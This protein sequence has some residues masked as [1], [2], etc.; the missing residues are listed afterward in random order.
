MELGLDCVELRLKEAL[1]ETRAQ[2]EDLQR[3]AFAQA[4]QQ[5]A[6]VPVGGSSASTSGF[7]EKAVRLVSI[8][9]ANLVSKV[10]IFS[11][12]DED[13]KTWRFVFESTTGLIFGRR[14]WSFGV[15]LRRDRGLP[16]T[17]RPRISSFA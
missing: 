5:A 14:A 7:S 16:T 15:G 4:A 2:V 9:D 12:N 13:W 3:G 1:R 17:Y 8:I 10:G 6:A 11:G